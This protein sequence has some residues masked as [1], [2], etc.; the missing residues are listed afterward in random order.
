[1]ALVILT[2]TEQKLIEWSLKLYVFQL[3]FLQ[4]PKNVTFYVFSLCCI[5]FLEQRA[6]V[7]R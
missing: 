6:K 3:F 7:I 1:M 5:R 4:N 2:L